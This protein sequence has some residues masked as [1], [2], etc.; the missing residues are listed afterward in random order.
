MIAEQKRWKFRQ[1][2]ISGKKN[3]KYFARLGAASH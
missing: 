3:K 2:T 1:E